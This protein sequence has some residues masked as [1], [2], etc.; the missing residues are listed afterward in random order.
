MLFPI[1][2]CCRLYLCPTVCNTSFF[3]LTAFNIFYLFLILSNLIIRG[4]S[5][6]FSM[7]LRFTV[8]VRFLGLLFSSYLDNFWPFVRFSSANNSP[9]GALVTHTY[10]SF[11]VVNSL[12]HFLKNYFFCLIAMSLITNYF[13]CNV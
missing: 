8:L 5:V 3:S 11:K 7:C 1:R 6:V 10:W 2:I 4:L 9:S 12:I 13:F